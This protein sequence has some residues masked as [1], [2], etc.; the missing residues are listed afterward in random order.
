MTRPTGTSGACR[1]DRASVAD[2]RCRSLQAIVLNLRASPSLLREI[3][4][5][6]VVREVDQFEAGLRDGSPGLLVLPENPTDNDIGLVRE[7]LLRHPSA[8]WLVAAPRDPEVALTLPPGA[9]VIWHDALRRDLVREI[10]LLRPSDPEVLLRWLRMF[11][12]GCPPIVGQC[13]RALAAA[14]GPRGITT[15]KELR[16]SLGVS[17]SYLGR[18]WRELPHTVRL[19]HIVDTVVGVR[20]LVGI[21]ETRPA[22][23]RARVARVCRVSESTVSR[24]SRRVCE[25]SFSSLRRP[26]E[27]ERAVR[28]IEGRLSEWLDGFRN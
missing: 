28:R 12:I 17:S 20:L 1:L 23:T 9:K 15:V 8:G 7:L 11:R 10:V 4:D 27:S 13:L 5:L 3:P 18:K 21:R 16:A 26:A 24:I 2:L 14:D 25:R 19:K 22:S 6:A